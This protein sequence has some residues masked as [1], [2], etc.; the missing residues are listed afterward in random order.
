MKFEC[1][2]WILWVCHFQDLKEKEKAGAQ[3]LILF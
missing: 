2:E 1:I 3:I